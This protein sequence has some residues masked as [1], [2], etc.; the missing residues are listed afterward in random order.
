[1]AIPDYQTV[2]PPLLDTVSDGEEH[3]IRDAIEALAERFNLN[4]AEKSELLPSGKQPTFNNRVS[5]AGTY[6]KEAG[7]IEKPRRGYLKITDRG[8]SLLEEKP[9]AINSK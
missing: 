5:W 2:M 3:H 6:M 1:M 4:E 7:L 8:L 9:K